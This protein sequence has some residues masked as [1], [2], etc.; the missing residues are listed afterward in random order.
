MSGRVIPGAK[1]PEPGD[2][3]HPFMIERSGIRGRL[4]RLGPA[5]DTIVRRPGYPEPVGRLLAEL[6]ALGTTLASTLK[7][8]GSFTLQI[9]GSEAVRTMV[10]DATSDG[11]LRGY[12]G[13]D[14]DAVA[15]LEQAE[16]PLSLPA[17]VGKGHMAFTVDQGEFTERYQGL[18]ALTGES[19]LDSLLH[20]FRQSQ[21]VNAG[22]LVSVQPP[23]AS[24][25][26][27]WRAGALLIEQVPDDNAPKFDRVDDEDWRRALI[28]MAS[29]TDSELVEPALAP[30]DLLFRLFHEEGVRVFE[31]RPVSVGCRCTQQ[32]ME[33]VLRS[34]DR[35]ELEEFKVE[36]KV[37]LT[38]E[39]C[40]LDFPFDD[41]DLDRLYRAGDDAADDS[42]SERRT[43]AD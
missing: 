21:Q 29:C 7:Y 5:L 13:Y 4:L 27:E 1:A 42:A 25:S 20:Y 17:W 8:D 28:L 35:A 30:N 43:A 16:T 32:R 2:L 26:G 10:M 22:I 37:V 34:I 18:V 3:V 41:G 19:L 14:A 12:A 9:K 36:G 6:V 15:A 24:A 39:F 11:A 38:C 23:Q 31:P 40:A 33:R